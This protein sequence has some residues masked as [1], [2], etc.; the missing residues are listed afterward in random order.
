MDATGRP[1]SA[2]VEKWR[3]ANVRFRQSKRLYRLMREL[4]QSAEESR[5]NAYD[6]MFE[7]EKNRATAWLAL[8]P[9]EQDAHRAEREQGA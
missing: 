3:E 6:S 2:A 8:T 9:A 5:D 4:A 1:M 7:D